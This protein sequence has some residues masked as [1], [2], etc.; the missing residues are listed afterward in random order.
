MDAQASSGERLV[1]FK[2]P[3]RFLSDLDASVTAKVVASA[4]D[5]ALVIDNGVIKDIALGSGDL[6]KEGYDA[7]WRGKKWIETV[8]VES[9]PKI[10]DLL[11]VTPSAT[12]HW[13]HVNHPSSAGL[14][15][16]IKYTA[17]PT[18]DKNRIVALGRD[19]RSMAALQQ[20]LVEAHQGLERDYDRLREAEA[21]Y[22]LLFQSVSE[23]VLV[24]DS[25]T[26]K[27]EEANPAAAGYFGK[28]AD[29]LADDRL[30][31][32]FLKKSQPHIEAA[33]ADALSSGS[34]TSECVKIKGGGGCRLSISPFRFR[35]AVRLIVRIMPEGDVASQGSPHQDVMGVLLNIPDGMVVASEDLRILTA[36][37][38]FSDMARLSGRMQVVGRR[39]SDFVGRSST[40][41]N[42]LVSNIKSHG[43][44]RNFSTILKDQFGVEERVEISAVAAPS[45]AGDV[46]GF[47]IRNVARRLT[48]NPRISEQ[49]PSSVDQLT[50][51]VG[52]VALKDIVREST[53]L[54]EKLCIEAA[55]EITEDNRASAAEMLGLSRQG[56]YSKLKRFGFDD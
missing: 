2:S 7:S 54:I 48:A 24:V 42:V 14:D 5:V 30:S 11:K 41:M 13:R 17:V 52:K 28:T 34:V 40:D 8:T 50:G 18:G 31:D 26:F 51:L 36:N 44:V 39:L 9:R 20:R 46:Y 35:N 45:E 6:S 12:P 32:H 16:P 37:T 53:D 1:S 38:A 56:L 10:E 19:L 47:S 15:V 55:L 27:I 4:A 33:V 3:K 25:R 29:L 43:S 21:R 23:A 22:R 49:L